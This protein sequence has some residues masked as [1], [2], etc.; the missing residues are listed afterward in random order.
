MKDNK[1]E[2]DPIH[3]QIIFQFLEDTTKGQFNRKT[4]EGILVVEH[5][6]NQLEDA[7][8][9]RVLAIGPEVHGINVDDIVLIENLRWT[10]KFNVSETTQDY[11]ITQ[12]K[13]ILAT[14]DDPD[15]LPKEV[16]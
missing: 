15:N 2:L 16:A 13:E 5:D 8:W 11:W 12:E 14:W 3:D 10:N 9:G 4:S 6:H 7:R 1:T